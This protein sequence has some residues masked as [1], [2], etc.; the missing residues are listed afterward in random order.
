SASEVGVK[1][2]TSRAKRG[3]GGLLTGQDACLIPVPPSPIEGTDGTME[4]HSD[5]RASPRWCW[6]AGQASRPVEAFKD[7]MVCAAGMQGP[8]FEEAFRV[9]G[10][11]HREYREAVE[12]HRRRPQSAPR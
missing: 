8:G 4:V 3:P 5:E 6:S 2:L 11:P 9:R 12:A 1:H 7:V 10:G